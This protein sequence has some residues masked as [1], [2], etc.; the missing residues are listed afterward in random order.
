MKSARF[1]Y[2][3]PVDVAGAIAAL[4]QPNARPFAGGQSLGPMLN[5]RLARPSLL[6][7]VARLPDLRTTE[8]TTQGVTYGAAITHAE[9]EDAAVPDATNGVLPCI[10]R[11]IAY[12]A[13]RNRGTIGG[14]LAHADPAADWVTTLSALGAVVRIAGPQG[15]RGVP[16][17]AFVTGAFETVLQPQEIVLAVFVPALSPNARWGYAKICRKVGEFAEAMCAVLADSERGVFRMAIGAVE[18]R[19]IVITDA[20]EMIEEPALLDPLLQ[21]AS[22]EPATLK[23]RQSVIRRAIAATREGV[24]R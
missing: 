7:D 2:V 15:E 11:G 21:A 19:P 5:L 4:A 22:K 24:G 1:D 9:F 14:S 20:R 10:A 17:D 12:R 3:R 18:A 6:V 16:V 23:L 8:K 13:V